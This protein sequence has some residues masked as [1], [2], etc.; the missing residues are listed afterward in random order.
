MKLVKYKLAAFFSSHT[1]QELPHNII[2]EAAVKQHLPQEGSRDNPRMLLGGR[3][4]RFISVF[5][6]KADKEKRMSFLQS[7][8][9]SKKGMPRAGLAA[10]KEKEKETVMKLTQPEILADKTSWTML[11]WADANDLPWEVD[12]V[13]N[14]TT[15]KAQLRRT[16]KELFG[17]KKMTFKD[18][19]KAFFP[20]TSANYINNRKNAGAIGSILEHPRILEGLRVSGGYI[21]NSTLTVG[22]ERD[23]EEMEDEGRMKVRLDDSKFQGAFTML[24]LRVLT[25]ASV[26]RPDAEPVALPEALKIRVITKGPPFIQ[27]ALRNLWKFMHGVL[28]SHKTFR[29]IGEQVS[30][31]YV[32]DVLGANLPEGQ[33]YLSGDYEA[34]TDNL[35]SWVSEEIANAIADEIG[36]YEIERALFITSLTKHILRGQKQTTGQLMGSIT[37]F[38]V[39]CIANAAFCRWALEMDF[40]KK[41][42]LRDAPM[43]VNGD[44]CMLRIGQFGRGIWGRITKFGGLPPSVG[45]CFYSRE[46]VNIN[47]TN[48]LRDEENP[49]EEHIFYTDSLFTKRF[50]PFK[51][52]L[53]VN[54]GLMTGLKRSGLSIGLSDQDDPRNNIGVRYRELIRLSPP[55]M[56]N[57]IHKGF[58]NRHR[59]LLEK[60]R[61]PWYIPEWL[62]GLGLTGIVEPSELDLR[63]AHMILL[64]WETRRPISLAHQEATWKTWQLAQKALPKPMLT[65]EKNKG[66]EEYK[67]LVAKKCIDLLFDLNIDLETLMT[68]V[69]KGEGVNKAIK[70]NA[71]IWSPKTYK[72]L[73]KPLKMVDIEFRAR[74]DSL[75]GQKP[76]IIPFPI[77]DHPTLDKI[78]TLATDLD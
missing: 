54:M 22:G 40:Q 68:E 35:K 26:E 63:I 71:V 43:A 33:A 56:R 73:A 23:E 51:L 37:S 11:S 27:T 17:G 2:M 76:D 18:R 55:S 38:P 4:G 21:N 49:T 13:L 34:A 62:G 52:N 20:S 46:F 32:R 69:R 53:Y 75:Q 15:M 44:D 41:L 30:A 57:E 58:V 28:R 74:Y 14:E 70:R 10:L 19:V 61:L 24:W 12:F 7:I 78:I 31:G 67:D 64:N 16:V 9:Q 29:L 66:V 45:K 39:L 36:L 60:A 47:S 25:E 1:G 48:Y 42:L 59:E 77:S 6:K 65:F 5:L 3:L 50:N 8:L 72:E